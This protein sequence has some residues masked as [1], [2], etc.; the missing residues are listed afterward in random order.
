MIVGKQIRNL[1][2][3][4]KPIKSTVAAPAALNSLPEGGTTVQDLNNLFPT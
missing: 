2:G 4:Q 1:A 3:G